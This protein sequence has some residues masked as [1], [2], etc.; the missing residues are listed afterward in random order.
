MRFFF[1]WSGGGAGGGVCVCVSRRREKTLKRKR[2][3]KGKQTNQPQLHCRASETEGTKRE[4]IPVLLLPLEVWPP[5][6]QRAR[7]DKLNER[8]TLCVSPSRLDIRQWGVGGGEG[9][10]G[11]GGGVSA[12]HVSRGPPS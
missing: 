11:G 3:K 7:V 6:S 5:E 1:F 8:L 9:G 10:G 4:K 2:K 12:V